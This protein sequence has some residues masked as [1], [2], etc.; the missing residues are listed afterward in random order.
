V[1]YSKKTE[2]IPHMY[3]PNQSHSRFPG[4]PQLYVS[5]RSLENC[6]QI[7][8]LTLATQN[9]RQQGKKWRI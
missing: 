8:L 6:G 3:M 9:K 5:M 7:F 4:S 1:G 2:N